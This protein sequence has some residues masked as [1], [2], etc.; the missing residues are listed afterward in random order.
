[1]SHSGANAFLPLQNSFVHYRKKKNLETEFIVFHIIAQVILAFWLA[2]AY[3]L[4]E[5]RRTIGV[6]TT[7]FF[8]LCF[9]TVAEKFENLNNILRD[10]AKDLRYKKV[11][12][13]Y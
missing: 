11:L 3:D 2:L 6:I 1:M 10:W 8:P 4:L 9:K 7:K 12:S 5:D 13:R